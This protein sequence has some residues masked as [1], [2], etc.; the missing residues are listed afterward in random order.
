MNSFFLLCQPT[1]K[2]GEILGFGGFTA[3]KPKGENSCEGVGQSQ[4]W[5]YGVLVVAESMAARSSTP[6]FDAHRDG[7]HDEG[8]SESRE[9]RSGFDRR[10][11]GK[12]Q[13]RRRCISERAPA[14]R[15]TR[16]RHFPTRDGGYDKRSKVESRFS[17]EVHLTATAT[18]WQSEQESTN[19]K[20]FQRFM[21][22]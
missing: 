4:V 11:Q 22:V 20:G 6:C 8:A 15:S 21:R 19:W 2:L 10:G 14:R 3:L 13:Q 5:G 7:G 16:A 9:P 1:S 18:T 17:A 12:L